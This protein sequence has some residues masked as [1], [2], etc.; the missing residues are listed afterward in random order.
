M[1]W[2]LG[3]KEADPLEKLD[4]HVRTV[5][6]ER[7]ANDVVQAL[8]LIEQ[9]WQ[10]FHDDEKMLLKAYGQRIGNKLILKIPSLISGGDDA[11]A[12]VLKVFS[13]TPSKTMNV[14]MNTV[15]G[16]LKNGKA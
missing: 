14:F 11:F 10:R 6:V 16:A 2:L 8:H 4:T 15:I 12:E 7:F 3:R 1:G 9:G 13:S 5:E